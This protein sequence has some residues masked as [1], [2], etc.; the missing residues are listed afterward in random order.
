MLIGFVSDEYF[1]ALA[2]VGLEF[3]GPGVDRLVTRSL[4]SGAVV[5]DIPPGEY[6]VVLCKPGFGNKRV[7]SVIDSKKPVHWRL[8][9]DRLLGYAWPKWC[10]GGD[11]VEF[12]VHS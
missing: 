5:A 2:D 12:R 7:R 10:K 11:K 9:S 3:R 1:A 8:L 6:D 4:P